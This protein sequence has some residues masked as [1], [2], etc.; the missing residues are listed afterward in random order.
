MI[1]SVYSY[2][3]ISIEHSLGLFMIIEKSEDH[4]LFLSDKTNWINT[5]FFN[6]KSTAERKLVLYRDLQI[7]NLLDASY[8]KHS[9][10]LAQ[11]SVIQLRK[12][13]KTGR[14]TFEKN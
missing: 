8:G 13:K 14:I 1:R 3:D 6:R 10:C 9:A 7:F 2:N 11:D 5:F 12:W 4:P